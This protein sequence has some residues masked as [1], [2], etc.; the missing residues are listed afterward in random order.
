LV[1]IGEIQLKSL[2]PNSYRTIFIWQAIVKPPRFHGGAFFIL[3]LLKNLK[4]QN[5]MLLYGASGH[6]K[7][8]ISTLESQKEIISGILMMTQLKNYWM[9]IKFWVNMTVI[10]IP[11]KKLSL[12]LVI[13]L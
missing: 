11:M 6:G 8:I 12:L 3:S 9:T 4:A 7:V 1:L 2:P 5:N 10:Y 13:I